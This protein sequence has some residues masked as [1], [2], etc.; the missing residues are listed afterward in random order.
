MTETEQGAIRLGADL[1]SLRAEAVTLEL[2][3][4][5]TYLYLTL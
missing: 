2:L 4:M 3:A 5:K 1:I